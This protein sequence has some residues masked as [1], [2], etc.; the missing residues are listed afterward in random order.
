[1]NLTRAAHRIDHLDIAAALRSG[2][3]CHRPCA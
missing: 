3:K 2:R 1:M